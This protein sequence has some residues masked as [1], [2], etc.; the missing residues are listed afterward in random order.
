MSEK[1]FYQDFIVDSSDDYPKYADGIMDEH[2]KPK[3][4]IGDDYPTYEDNL[5]QNFVQPHSR[6]QENLDEDLLSCFS[7][8][9]RLAKFAIQPW[10]TE[11]LKEKTQNKIDKVEEFYKELKNKG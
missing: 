11:E 10:W 5:K 1:Y 6:P 3:E 4:I 7:E 8:V 9:L 2:P